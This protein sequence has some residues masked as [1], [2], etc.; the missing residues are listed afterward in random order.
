MPNQCN[1]SDHMMVVA[2][3]PLIAVPLD[4]SPPAAGSTT[5]A[6]ATASIASAAVAAAA[7]ERGA[8]EALADDDD[9]LDR[10]SQIVHTSWLRSTTGLGVA[11]G[12]GDGT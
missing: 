3:V 5:A 6:A 2:V 10:P 1:P 8:G 12:Q 11:D 7:A 9:G 4:I